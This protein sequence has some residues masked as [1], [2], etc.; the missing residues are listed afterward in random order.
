MVNIDTVYQRVLVFANK[1]QRGYITPQE[2]NIFAGQAQLEIIEQYFYDIN[3]FERGNGNN[4]E[5][6]D[7][8]TLIQEKLGAL[9]KIHIFPKITGMLGFH[10]LPA[11][12]YKIGTV[13]KGGV[14]REEI[15]EITYSEWTKYNKSPLTKFTF[16][17]RGYVVTN[18]DPVNNAS[19]RGIQVYPNN[20]DMEGGIKMSYVKKPETPRWGYFVVGGKAL[21][22]T[23]IYD[24][25]TGLGKTTHFELHEAEETEL[26]YKILKFAGLS[27][28]RDDVAKGGQGLE[29]ISVQQEK[30]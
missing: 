22:D 8:V 21:H 24:P 17:T 1:E 6:S 2:F 19:V 26:V 28:R 23:S 4:T 3:Q 10:P 12:C 30:Q 14:I 7:M 16:N 11:D 25:N 20:S 18:W 15:D 29:S 27:M 9:T 13:T 5:Y